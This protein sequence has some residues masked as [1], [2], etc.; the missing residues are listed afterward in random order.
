MRTIDF[1]VGLNQAVN[2]VVNPAT[3]AVVC[4]STLTNP[5]DGCVPLNLFGAGNASK[6]AINYVFPTLSEDVSYTQAVV[7][8]N[9]HGD[10][11]QG[12]GAGPIR[13]A[14]GAEYRHEYGNVTHNL[15]N[16][17]FYNSYELSYGLDYRDQYHNL[18]YLAVLEPGEIEN[19]R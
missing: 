13:L 19:Q 17:P 1:L 8:G 2:A 18:P 11:L 10:V 7:S 12:W 9:I 4:R 5:T 3:G 16:Q 6:A 14:S 15:A